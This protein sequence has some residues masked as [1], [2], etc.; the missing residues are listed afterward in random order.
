MSRP[1]LRQQADAVLRVAR[2]ECVKALKARRSEIDL[3]LEQLR[4]AAATLAKLAA[5]TTK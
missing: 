1:T 3:T 2:P 4:A 5:E